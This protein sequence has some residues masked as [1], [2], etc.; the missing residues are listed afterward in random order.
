LATFSILKSRVS[1]RLGLD[2]TGS[3]TEDVLVGYELNDAVREVLLDL[4]INVN[5][6]TMSLTAGQQNY[7]LDAAILAINDMSI[8]SGSYVYRLERTTPDEILRMRGASAS[9]SQVR[10]YALNGND[11]LMVYPTPA[12]ADV[13]TILYVPRP[14]EMSSGSHDPSDETY[15]GI[16]VEYHNALIEYAAWKMADYD[17]DQSSQQGVMYQGNYE[18]LLRKYK[19]RIRGKGGRSQG[20]AVVG[21]R[22]TVPHN[23]SQDV[24]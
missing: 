19:R 21:R 23:P 5:S 11:L 8:T 3:G 17:D 12:A 9:T 20:R 18:N 2:E 6:S 4:K 16:P 22:P 10:F 14:T 15:G 1:K 13:I 7:E 24:W